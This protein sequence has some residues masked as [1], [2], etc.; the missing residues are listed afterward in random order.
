MRF[1]RRRSDR[2]LLNTIFCIAVCSIPSVISFQSRQLRAFCRNNGNVDLS[3]SGAHTCWRAFRSNNNNEDN[4]K[5]GERSDVSPSNNDNKVDC[6]S[7]KRRDLLI[8]TSSCCLGLTGISRS[9]PTQAIDVFNRKGLYVLN[10]RDDLSASSSR[11]EQVEVVPKLSSECALLRVLPVKNSVFRTVEQNLEALSVLRYRRD[12]SLENIDKA[13]AKAELSIDTALSIIVNKRN[14]LEAVFNPDDSTEVA[15][16]KA[17]RGEILLG[18]LTQD[19][20]YLKGSIALRVC[21]VEY[22]IW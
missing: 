14:Q 7:R 2:R 6:F 3:S 20:E 19:L 1:F 16:L 17:E 10:T 13:W 9:D 22:T 8:S 12:T 18:D 21:P 4:S 5:I 11:N 15:I